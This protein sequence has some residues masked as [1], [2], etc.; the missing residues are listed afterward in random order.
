MLKM[1]SQ[2]ARRADEFGG[3]FEPA[4]EHP[5]ILDQL[6]QVSIYTDCLGKAHPPLWKNTVWRYW[7]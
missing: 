1:F 4:A 5:Y 6:K 7:M 2:G 3:L